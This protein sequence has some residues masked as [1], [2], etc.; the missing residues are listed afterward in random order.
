LIVGK[1]GAYRLDIFC[2]VAEDLPRHVSRLAENGVERDAN[3]PSDESA[4]G[5]IE[6]VSRR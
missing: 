6:V 4:I 3:Q 1:F 2:E 5:V